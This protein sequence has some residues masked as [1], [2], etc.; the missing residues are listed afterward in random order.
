MRY[1]HPPRLHEVFVAS[2][3]YTFQFEGKPRGLVEHWTI[4]EQ[5]GGAQVIRVDRDDR[6]DYGIT[7]LVEAWRSPIMDGGRIE[8]LDI[9]LRKDR[10]GLAG[11]VRGSY[12]FFG[13]S[14]QW[15]L[16]VDGEER[17]NEE[18]ALP[19]GYVVVPPVTFFEG[20][21]RYQAAQQPDAVIPAAYFHHFGPINIDSLQA[22]VGS[23]RVRPVEATTRQINGRD[24]A[25]TRCDYD[26]YDPLVWS[27][28]WYYSG[29]VWVDEHGVLIE[30][31]EQ[32]VTLT[33]Y[34]RRPD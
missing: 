11:E 12:S 22:V 16:I 2:G 27:K 25:V 17:P 8:R 28:V 32:S 31:P 30:Q 1:I 6:K 4:H 7:T 15:Q 10:R 18:L 14:M 34:A 29:T 21:A 5:A 20:F 33:Q 13:D 23:M 3:M 26:S 19:P 9:F 24:I